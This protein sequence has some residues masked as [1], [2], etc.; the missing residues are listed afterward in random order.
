MSDEVNVEFN[1]SNNLLETSINDF[2][3]DVEFN[4]DDNTINIEADLS[5][6]DD[7]SIEGNINIPTFDLES[8]YNTELELSRNYNESS[9]KPSI[10]G[11]TL[12]GDKTSDDL[13]LV[14]NEKINENIVTD[15]ISNYNEDDVK[16]IIKQKNFVT[17]QTTDKEEKL[18]LASESNAGL[19]SIKNYNQIKNNEMSIKTLKSRLDTKIRTV[20]E[21][22]GDM[23]TGDYIFLVKGE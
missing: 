3:N 15:V 19:M 4:V 16:L 5:S 8:S 2:Q 7:P 17:G 22:P 9:N 21:V 23:K 20:T 13:H 18:K 1:P 11:V 6:Q 14:G 12:I 10:N